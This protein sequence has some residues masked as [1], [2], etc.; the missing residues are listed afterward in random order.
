MNLIMMDQE[1][2]TLESEFD[3]V[4]INTTAAREHVDEI[5]QSIRTIIERGQSILSVLPY[6][7]LHKQLVIHIIYYVVMFLN[8]ML[9]K[10][11]ISDTISPRMR[12]RLDWNKHCT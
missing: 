3:I 1:F 6:T 12:R 5:E 11:G 9:S 8:T 4:E 10:T 7:T 2:A